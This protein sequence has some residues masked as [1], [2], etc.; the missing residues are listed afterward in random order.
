[1]VADRREDGRPREGRPERLEV[2]LVVVLV[3]PPRIDEVS[4]VQD[5]VRV[6]AA[7]QGADPVDGLLRTARVAE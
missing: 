1:M 5:E 7:E 6:E 2:L 3:G 4:Q